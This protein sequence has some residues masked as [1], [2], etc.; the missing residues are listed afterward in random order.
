MKCIVVREEDEKKIDIKSVRDEV[1]SE[2][3]KK[4]VYQRIT[5]DRANTTHRFDKTLWRCDYY[6][7]SE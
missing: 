3:R 6:G 2:R 1:S 7:R 5:L 4:L